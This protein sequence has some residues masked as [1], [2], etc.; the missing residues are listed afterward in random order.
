M[1]DRVMLEIRQNWGEDVTVFFEKSKDLPHHLQILPPSY[2]SLHHLRKL[3]R[4]KDVAGSMAF[5]N[6]AFVNRVLR[7]LT[8][9]AWR[10]FQHNKTTVADISDAVKL[11]NEGQSAQIEDSEIQRLKK[12]GIPL[13]PDVVT[14]VLAAP[15]IVS[16]QPRDLPA[17]PRLYSE[18]QTRSAASEEVER[19]RRVQESEFRASLGMRTSTEVLEALQRESE[20]SNAAKR[21]RIRGPSAE[22]CT[23]RGERLQTEEGYVVGGSDSAERVESQEEE[24]AGVMVE[25]EAEFA[26]K[27]RLSHGGLWCQP[28]PHETKVSAA[29]DFYTAFH[30]ARTLPI[31]TCT[32]C[33]RK[34][35]ETKLEEV[36]WGQWMSN[37]MA[38]IRPTQLDCR[39]CFP[40]GEKIPAC[41]ECIRDIGRGV[42][43]PAARLHGWLGCEHTFPDELKGLSP[44]EEKLIALNSCYGFITKYSVVEG[45]KRNSQGAGY[46]K[47][48]K[49]HLTVFPNNVQELIS[50]VLPHPLLK[51]LDDIHVSWQG[52]EKPAPKDLSVLLSVRRSAVESALLWLKRNNPLYADIQID[53]AE[54]ESWDSPPH[55]VPSQVYERLERNEPSA[56]E[57]TR[58]AHV[59]PPTERGLE[60]GRQVDVRE[61][62]ETL[63]RGEDVA[64][65]GA[66]DG[67]QEEE[68]EATVGAEQGD[69]EAAAIQEIGSSGMFNLDGIPD[70]TDAEKLQY[71]Y[72][73]LG[74][75]ASGEGDASKWKASAQVRQE[76]GLE[77]Y[78]LVSRGK[79]FAEYSDP[80]FFAKT[81]PTL[82]PFGKG[83]PRQA[84]ETTDGDAE[85]VTTM[86]GVVSSRN[87]SIEAWARLVLRRHG[88]RFATHRV[89]PFLVFN[90]LVRFRNRNVSMMSVKKKNFGEV[91]Q[92]IRS[93]TAERLEKARTEMEASGKTGD[94]DVYQLLR[95]LSP[96]GFR[97]PMSREVRLSMRR[98][99]KSGIIHYGIPAIWFT[100]N[101]NDI[102]NPVKLR[103]AAY[104]VL[105]P[106]EAEAFLTEL[107]TAYKKARLAISD[108][109]SSVEFFH[110]EISMFF[111]HYV[112]V[113]KDSV[114]GRVS[115]YFGAVETNER[116]ALHLHGLIWLHGNMHMSSIINDAVDTDGLSY[117]QRI[118][119][120]V[121]SVFT[122]VS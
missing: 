13:E 11:Q 42:L 80:S 106:E 71:V 118:I 70:I 30:D 47:H 44:V 3:S 63:N 57:K 75:D 103:L 29:A 91:E 83:G 121:D 116:G 36:E 1:K 86:A 64:I 53:T 72:D 56:Y 8:A 117:R 40:A 54:M 112:K 62:L 23:G 37:R 18:R 21:R 110:R 66:G 12:E 89:F 38:R 122:E 77:P 74:Q 97:Q 20:E 49:G 100:L 4:H 2:I 96:Y 81:F 10:G 84:E 101:P 79:D 92:I 102:T 28:I 94:K 87:L 68:G 15:W 9:K 51:V 60:A 113:G 43:S 104:Q 33:Y 55:G 34:F 59:V 16:S 114:F 24:L 17:W 27:E 90:M 35:A 39:R 95:F 69:V 120:Y 93:L 65:E 52:A 67:G 41:A 119:E 46:V 78:I 98:K 85:T 105:D 25:L 32:V 111:E 19:A 82:F 73:A 115:H 5:I 22:R 14:G 88:G 61:I 99:I 109:L 7:E 6:R 50:N 76:D 31:R 45:Q 108:P 26:E 58:T 107:D 48:I